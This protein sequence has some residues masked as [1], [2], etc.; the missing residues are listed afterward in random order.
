MSKHNCPNCNCNYGSKF[1]RDWLALKI[2]QAEDKGTATAEE[3][4]EARELLA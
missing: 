1:L 4:A 3:L 2:E